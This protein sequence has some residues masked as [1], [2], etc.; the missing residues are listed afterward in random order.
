LIALVAT[1]LFAAYALGPDLLA[2]WML[3]FVV[4]RKNL[5]L[6]KS[7]EITRGIIWSIVP[8]G[9]AWSL[10]HTGLFSFP[11]NAKIDLQLFFSS[12][13]SESF[14]NQHRDE[15]FAAAGSFWQLNLC[16]WLRL[17]GIVLI[18]SLIFNL[19]ISRYGRIRKWLDKENSW[20]GETIRWLL[21]TFI[22]PRIAEWHVI[23]SP[24]LLGSKEMHIEVDVLA[25]N[26][27]LYAGR[28]ADKVL[29]PTGEL[30]SVTLGKPRRFKREEYLDAK[31]AG[32]NVQSD[33]F[34]KPIPSELFVI[35]GSEISTINVRHIP[36]VP[37]FAERYEDIAELMHVIKLKLEKRKGEKK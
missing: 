2:R 14:F 23:L 22:L 10:R 27:I 29:S 33:A 13:Y 31:K 37:Q 3:G 5:V 30:Q 21:T 4:P 15:F 35:V 26:D 25:K 11:P 6:S 9:L 34:W 1:F 18:A 7:E 12:L 20:S 19:L 36:S 16:L 8:F 24:V 32:S 28:L 17:Y